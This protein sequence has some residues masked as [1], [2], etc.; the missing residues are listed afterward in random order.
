MVQLL[1]NVVVGHSHTTRSALGFC[2]PSAHNHFAL[3]PLH[4]TF[5]KKFLWTLPNRPLN[6]GEC[7]GL[8]SLPRKASLR[9]QLLFF[10]TEPTSYADPARHTCT[11][12]AHAHATH[13]GLSPS[14][15][16]LYLPFPTSALYYSSPPGQG[17]L[18]F[19]FLSLPCPAPHGAVP[20][21]RPSIRESIKVCW[22]QSHEPVHISWYLGGSGWGHKTLGRVL[23]VGQRRKS[24]NLVVI[25]RSL[26][27]TFEQQGP[28]SPKL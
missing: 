12:T 26:T 17:S 3:R 23:E 13:P 24:Q 28:P 4:S 21:Q 18:S 20:P 15:L 11:C 25:M 6:R 9:S 22:L 16:A 10:H 1:C 27:P 5:S 19:L 2:T 14:T 7:G 8:A